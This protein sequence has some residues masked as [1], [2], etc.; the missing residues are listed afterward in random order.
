MRRGEI[1][2]DGDGLV[3]ACHGLIQLPQFFER[4]A[5]VVMRPG[6]IGLDG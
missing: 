6:V 1:G 2:L 4:N 3:V 5:K